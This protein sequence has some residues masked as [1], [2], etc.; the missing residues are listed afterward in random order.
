MRLDDKRLCFV[1]GFRGA[2]GHRACSLVVWTCWLVVKVVL[3]LGYSNRALGGELIVHALW[4]VDGR[5]W[6]GGGRRA[7]AG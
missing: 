1:D 7:A 2:M 4:L 6:A 3:V 5:G